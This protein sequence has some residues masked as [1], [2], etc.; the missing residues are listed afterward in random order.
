MSSFDVA[1]VTPVDDLV[2]IC[3]V[4]EVDACG[5]PADDVGAATSDRMS[6]PGTEGLGG[7]SHIMM[8]I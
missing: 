2:V 8:S 4:V 5:V 3:V 1:E 7:V 6:L